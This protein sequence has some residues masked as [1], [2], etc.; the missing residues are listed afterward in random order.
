MG[1]ALDLFRPS[2]YVRAYELAAL[3]HSDR[4]MAREFQVS[5]DIFKRWR[6][7]KPA[8]EESIKKGRGKFRQGGGLT[9]RQKA[10]CR[11][12]LIDLNAKRAA[13]RAGY[14]QKTAYISGHENL[15]SPRI[16]AHLKEKM[17]ER[18]KACEIDAKWVLQRLIRI[19][20]ANIQDAYD[21]EGNRRAVNQL[22]RDL[23]YALRKVRTSPRV[24]KD[25]LTEEILEISVADQRAA[26]ELIGKHL[27]MFAEQVNV[28]H[29]G[30]LLLDILDAK[31]GK[32]PLIV[33]DSFIEKEAK[34]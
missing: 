19:A 9:E 23:A 18:A 15:R 8:F 22:P 4:K 28:K 31:E 29:D 20:D 25:G 7:L 21:E 10:F 32:G 33:D 12:Y 30:A 6:Q 17:E 26:L 2:Y 5:P 34:G 27:G 13:I 1:K 16:Q 24:K 3:G 11:E 14:S